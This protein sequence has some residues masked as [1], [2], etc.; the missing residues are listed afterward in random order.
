M[1]GA[2]IG[3]YETVAYPFLETELDVL[4]KRLQRR[5]PT[6]GICLGSQ[7]MAAALGA[8][9]YPGPQGREIGWSTL[10]E[11]PHVAACPAMAEFLSK[12]VR[13]LHWHG[14]TFDLPPGVAHLAS[15]RLYANQAWSID[16]YALAL[17]F[18][19][20]VTAAGLE[21]WY[22]GH[23]CE[24]SAAAIDVPTLRR[25]GRT[26]APP[27]ERAAHGFWHR[28]L[29]SAFAADVHLGKTSANRS[30]HHA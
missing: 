2:P 18:H 25:E 11:G 10:E 20:E 9:V 22:V 14:D 26:H 6:I 15:T 28:W 21:R 7:L 8:V 23:A 16:G 27:L 19:P 17:Q 3:V 29:D 1:L 24:L 4:R 30:I 5:A 13:V 12:G